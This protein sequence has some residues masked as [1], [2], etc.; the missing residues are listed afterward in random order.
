MEKLLDAFGTE[1]NILHEV[2]VEAL[3]S[4]AGSHIARHI[5]MAREQKLAFE[6][7]GGGIYGRVKP[8]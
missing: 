2:P 4:V 8:S 5:L 3:E 6:E 7:G 1:M